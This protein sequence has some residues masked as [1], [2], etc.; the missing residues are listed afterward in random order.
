MKVLPTSA[1]ASPFPFR[2]P[3]FLDP[4]APPV[5]PVELPGPCPPTLSPCPSSPPSPSGLSSPAVSSCLAG[6]RLLSSRFSAPT[7]LSRP[8]RA[9]ALSPVSARG[10]ERMAR[11]R[12]SSARS[13]SV[14]EGDLGAVLANRG[15]KQRNRVSSSRHRAVGLLSNCASS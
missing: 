5:C 4:L 13:S 8:P 14:G 7:P 3:P 12:R 15:V 6:R 2:R 11:C 9:E 10:R 1:L